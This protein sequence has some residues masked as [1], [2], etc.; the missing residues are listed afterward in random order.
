MNRTGNG[1]VPDELS[2]LLR[3]LGHEVRFLREVLPRTASDADI[4]AYAWQNGCL[5]VTCNRDDFVSLAETASHHGIIVVFRQ[6]TRTAEKAALLRLIENA[7][8]D[9][10]AN[11][12]NFA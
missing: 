7:G 5:V 8:P 2:H 10:L 1:D 6:K 12:I 9:G 4:L 3:Q 11:N